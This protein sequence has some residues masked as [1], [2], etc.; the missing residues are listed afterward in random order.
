MLVKSCQTDRDPSQTL[1]QQLIDFHIPDNQIKPTAITGTYQ[2]KL[3]KTMQFLVTVTHGT[4]VHV[5][6]Q[7]TDSV[8][9]SDSVL[10]NNVAVYF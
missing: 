5:S 6:Q 7:G 2:M 4:T 10:N 1:T 8:T 9:E 3:Q